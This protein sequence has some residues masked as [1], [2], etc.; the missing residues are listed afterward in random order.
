[1]DV[2]QILDKLGDKL[3]N[4]LTIKLS[5]YQDAEDVL[6]E[7]FYRVLKY[8]V[9]LQLKRNPS[10][11]L[12][13]IARN[14]AVNHIKKRKRDLNIRLSRGELAGVIQKSLKGANDEELNHISDALAKIP[15]DQRE[16]IVLK[17]FEGLTFKEIALI[18]GVSM[19]TITS[20]YR[21]G[22]QKLRQILE[23]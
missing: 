8:R 20:R 23:E 22:I 13:Q 3:Y 4:Y 1:M 10:A 6:Q 19:G 11:Y 14:E 21:Y 5:S 9:R 12:F 2:E 7:V 18:C 16:V 15:E 17:Y